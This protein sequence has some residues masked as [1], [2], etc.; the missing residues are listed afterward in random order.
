MPTLKKTRTHRCV[1][2]GDD[3]T[4]RVVEFTGDRDEGIVDQLQ[5]LVDGYFE[6]VRGG[7]AVAPPDGGSPEAVDVWGNDDVRFRSD[8]APNGHVVALLRFPV[9]LRGPAVMTVTDNEGNTSGLPEHLIDA[10]R[11]LLTEAGAEELPPPASRRRPHNSRKPVRSAQR[12]L[13][14]LRVRVSGV[15]PVRGRGTSVTVQA[16]A[17]TATVRVLVATGAAT[18]YA[19]LAVV[20]FAAHLVLRAAMMASEGPPHLV[21]VGAWFLI[22]IASGAVMSVAAWL[23]DRSMRPRQTESKGLGFLDG[24]L[25]GLLVLSASLL[26]GAGADWRQHLPGNPGSVVLF[27]GAGVSAV[28][29]VL[30]VGFHIRRSRSAS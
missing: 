8:L 4:F 22:L 15:V 19:V 10:V 24:L 14:H 21:V 18:A 13:G 26:T 11:G 5:R 7:A 9:V 30:T 20:G 17:R 3:G 27:V 1:F 23:Y 16:R 2:V 29:A 6:P 28:A 12:R 25:V